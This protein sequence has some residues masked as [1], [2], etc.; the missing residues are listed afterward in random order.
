VGQNSAPCPSSRLKG[1]PASNP[2]QLFNMTTR[3]IGSSQLR[4]FPPC[5]IMLRRLL[6][7]TRG[8]LILRHDPYPS[9]ACYNSAPRW[10]KIRVTLENKLPGQDRNVDCC[11]A[12]RSFPVLHLLTAC[13]LSQ[14][15]NINMLST[16]YMSNLRRFRSSNI[17]ALQVADCE[18]QMFIRQV[19]SHP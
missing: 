8:L 17:F 3:L 13:D 2:F 12:Q 19:G 7:S 9:Y 15:R 10:W 4:W 18:M 1:L 6:N 5:L 11:V 16:Q 14:D